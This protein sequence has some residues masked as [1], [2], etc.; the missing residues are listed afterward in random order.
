MSITKNDG[1]VLREQVEFT[2]TVNGVLRSLKEISEVKNGVLRKIFSKGADLP[3]SLV[4]SVDTSISGYD[5]N[6]KINSVSAD[7]LTIS[8]VSKSHQNMVSTTGI[9]KVCICSDTI[10]L[11]EGTTISIVPTSISGAGTTTDL[12]VTYLFTASGTQVES[13]ETSSTTGATAVLT[14][15]TDGEYQIRLGGYSITGGQ[16]TS[17]YTSTVSCEISFTL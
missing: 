16:T 17:Y 7:G 3:T 12:L 11:K 4:W 2:K 10:T 8:Y 15:P 9:K 13:A 6:S 5:T 1:G 14:V